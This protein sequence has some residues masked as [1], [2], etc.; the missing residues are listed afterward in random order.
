MLPPPSTALPHLPASQR[1]L[2]ES[3]YV[4]RPAEVAVGKDPLLYGRPRRP[5]AQLAQHFKELYMAVPEHQGGHRSPVPNATPEGSVA[6]VTGINRVEESD[7]GHDARQA[8]LLDASLIAIISTDIP[9]PLFPSLRCALSPGGCLT[10]QLGGLKPPLLA[11]QLPAS[12]VDYTAGRSHIELQPFKLEG[13]TYVRVMVYFSY[14]H[15]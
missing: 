11:Y 13:V 6:S 3:G 2:A 12:G 7:A 10:V 5:F 14:T 9:W 15:A 4:S 1:I 8:Q